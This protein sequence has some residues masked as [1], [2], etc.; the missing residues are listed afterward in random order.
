[1]ERTQIYADFLWMIKLTEELKGQRY[2]YVVRPVNQSVE[3]TNQ[4][5]EAREKI[6]SAMES[7]FEK[8]NEDIDVLKKK[9]TQLVSQHNTM[10]NEIK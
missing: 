8:T 7:G 5:D 3:E 6:V 4:V 10:N 1:M 9:V 2:L